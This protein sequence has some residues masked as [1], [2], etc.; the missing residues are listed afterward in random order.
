MAYSQDWLIGK[1]IHYAIVQCQLLLSGSPRQRKPITKQ[2]G[3]NWNLTN[4]FSSVNEM[5]RTE[6]WNFKIK[7]WNLSFLFSFVIGYLCL[8]DPSNSSHTVTLS[9]HKTAFCSGTFTVRYFWECNWVMFSC[10]LNLID[11]LA[12]SCAS[13]AVSFGAV[14][15]L[16][17]MF[18]DWQRTDHHHRQANIRKAILNVIKNVTMSSKCPWCNSVNFCYIHG[19][20]NDLKRKLGKKYWKNISLFNICFVLVLILWMLQKLHFLN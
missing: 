2:T 14:P 18:C 13:K 6:W 15:V 19:S 20:Y 17:Q 8:V 9:A 4:I 16:L 1:Q 3:N 12:E 11:S 7:S 5:L 10:R